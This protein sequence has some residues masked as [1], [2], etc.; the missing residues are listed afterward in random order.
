MIDW[1]LV[2]ISAIGIG[3]TALALVTLSYASWSAG[4]SLWRKARRNEL[5]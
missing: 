4:I 5:L 2:L 3:G 1:L